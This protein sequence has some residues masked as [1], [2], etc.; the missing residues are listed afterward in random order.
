MPK[1]PVGRQ[2]FRRPLGSDVCGERA[3][4]R[5]R[6]KKKKDAG[7]HYGSP[8]THFP[9]I[10]DRRA[11]PEHGPLC[12]GDLGLLSLINDFEAGGK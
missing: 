1:F 9:L 7:A 8:W 10:G 12:F 11:A 4:A 6:K 3:H 2:T 5:S